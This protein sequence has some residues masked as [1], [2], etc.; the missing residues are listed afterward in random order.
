MPRP[1]RPRPPAGAEVEASPST[2]STAARSHCRTHAMPAFR[3]GDILI[4][5]RRAAVAGRRPDHRGV[6]VLVGGQGQRIRLI[7]VFVAVELLVG[8]HDGQDELRT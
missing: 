4:A 6:A 2:P 3:A 7:G 5:V 1:R 8:G